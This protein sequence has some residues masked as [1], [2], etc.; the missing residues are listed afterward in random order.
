MG[1]ANGTDSFV[2]QD[3]PPDSD[4]VPVKAGQ[5]LG[6]QGR[7]SGQSSRPMWIHLRFS[8]VQA[9]EDGSFPGEV[10]PEDILNPSPYLGIA[11]KAAGGDSGWQPL[12]CKEE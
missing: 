1:S 10:A 6:Y 4:N 12:R 9:A 5:L 8:V 7:W 11:L 3:F 2:V